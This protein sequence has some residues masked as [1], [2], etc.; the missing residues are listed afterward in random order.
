MNELA[1]RLAVISAFV[2]PGLHQMKSRAPE[3]SEEALI[4]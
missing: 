3:I 4:E 1:V 2:I